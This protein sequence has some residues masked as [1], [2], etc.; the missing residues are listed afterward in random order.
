MR[1]ADTSAHFTICRP[2]QCD[3]CHRCIDDR[4]TLRRKHVSA[5]AS[6]KQ[7]FVAIRSG[8]MLVDIVPP[9]EDAL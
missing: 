6:R 8:V 4:I 9:V 5:F 3:R 2:S 1:R 7:R